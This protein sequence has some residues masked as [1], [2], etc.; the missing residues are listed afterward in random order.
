MGTALAGA[1]WAALWVLWV[2]AQPAAA[3]FCLEYGGMGRQLRL[4]SRGTR[5]VAGV[6]LIARTDRGRD[7]AGFRRYDF[8]RG[9][10]PYKYGFGAVPTDVFRVTVA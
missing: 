4:R 1:G 8:L 3:L 2:D 7:R 10:E 6:V 5:A 9:D